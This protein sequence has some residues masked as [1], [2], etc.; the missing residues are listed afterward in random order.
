MSEKFVNLT[1][2][3]KIFPKDPKRAK[4]PKNG[5]LKN[6]RIG[7]YFQNQNGYFI[8]GGTFLTST[9]FPK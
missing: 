6:E 7:L 1:P 3:P 9:Q 5:Q 2:N 4:G 8:L